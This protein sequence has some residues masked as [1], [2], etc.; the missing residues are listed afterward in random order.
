MFSLAQAPLLN[1]A[2]LQ[3]DQTSRGEMDD[4]SMEAKHDSGDK[5]TVQMSTEE[6]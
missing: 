2:P 5:E 1:N 4:D 3:I 6:D